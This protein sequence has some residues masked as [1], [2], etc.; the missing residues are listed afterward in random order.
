MLSC[1]LKNMAESDWDTVT[2]L[3]KKGPTVA[4]SKSKQAVAAAQR[5]GEELDT[6]KKWAAGQNKQHVITKNTAKLDRETEELQHQRVS[7]EVGKVIQQGRQN[8]GLTQKDLA[9]KINEKPQIIGDYESGKAIPN[10][11]VMGKIERAIGL[12]LRGK[13]IGKPLEAVPKKK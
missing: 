12:K 9:T 6:T 13:D 8:Q 11:Q 7:L 10:N 2:I 4:Q 1:K 3:R 5:R